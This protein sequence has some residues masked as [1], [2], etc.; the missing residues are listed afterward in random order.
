MKAAH[1]LD[2]LIAGTQMQMIGIRK[3][4]LRADALEIG[5]AQR[6]LDR[7]LRA[8]V[9]KDRR[10][11]RP[12]RAGELAAARLAL[13]FD[14]LEHSISFMCAEARDFFP[15]SIKYPM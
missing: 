12:M 1:G 14:D 9:H 11:H 3:L 6:A 8:D 7:R 13:F 5:S 2:R 10:L 15:Y 4:D